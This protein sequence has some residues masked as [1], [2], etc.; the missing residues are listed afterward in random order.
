MLSFT[1]YGL[2]GLLI[3]IV[4]LVA[5]NQLEMWFLAPR[6]QSGALS[7][8]WFIILITILLFADLFSLGGIL[9]ALPFLIFL[10]NYWKFYVI[11]RAR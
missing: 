3:G 2:I 11:K 1:T 4:I 8:H 6:I 10:R 9:I 5:A 7:I